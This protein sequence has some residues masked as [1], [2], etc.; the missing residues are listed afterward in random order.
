[1][2]W[3]IGCLGLMMAPAPLQAGEL[4]LEPGASATLS[5][6][7]S[8]LLRRSRLYPGQPEASEPTV[9]ISGNRTTTLR[10]QHYSGISP[11]ASA[12]FQSG[13][14]RHETTRLRIS[15][16]AMETVKI[17]GEFLQNDVDYDNKYS[18]GL[19]T[20]HYDLFLGEFPMTFKGSE[21]TLYE[22]SLQG[23]RLT[24]EVPSSSGTKPAV[25]FTL[26]SSSPRGKSQYE[27]FFGTDTQGP[28]KLK[29]SP[30]VLG[31][32]E[33]MVDKRRQVRNVDYEINYIT[34]YITFTK[35]IVESKSL[36]E[37]T[38]EA[39]KTV[40]P[41]GL[42]GG[43]AGWNITD[44]DSISLIG[45]DE[46]DGKSRD[47]YSFSGI[48]PTAHTIL[49][50][51]FRHDGEILR[52]G[53]EY[54]H[55]FY[56]PNSYGG[57]MEHGNAYRSELELEKSGL[58]LGGDI[59]RVEPKYQSMGNTALGQD[60]LGWSGYG[61]LGLGRLAALRGGHHQERS[62][63]NGSP[64]RLKTTDAKAEFTPQGWPREYYRF[65]QS[66]EVFEANYDRL[67]RRHTVDV[68]QQF[69]HLYLGSGYE[70]QEIIYRDGSQPDRSWDAGRA[71]L[72]LGGL[73]WA[74]ASFNGELRNGKES[75][76]LFGGSRKFQTAI[77]AANAGI[78]LHE[79]YYFGGSNRWQ[80][81]TGEAAQN[82]LR[83]D[84]RLRPIDQVSIQGNYSQETLQ[85]YLAGIRK[86]AR[87]DS[88]AALLETQPVKTLSFLYQPSLR[89]TVLSGTRPAVN[90]NRRDGYTAK[91]TTGSLLSAEGNCTVEDYRLRDTTDPGLR[92]QTS[93]DTDTWDTSVHLAPTTAF[94]SNISY[95]DRTSSK[96]Q[97]N[98]LSPA[99][100]DWRDTRQQAVSLGLKPQLEAKFGVDMGYR[101][102]RFRQNG[103]QGAATS[104][105]SFSISSITEKISSFSLLNDYTNLYIFNHTV[106]A[107]ASYQWVRSLISRANFTYDLKEDK[108]G[109][110]PP[111]TTISAGSG[112]TYRIKM[113]KIDCDYRL[114]QSRG[115]AGTFQQAVSSSL[116]FVPSPNVR[117]SN[118][119]EYA[120]SKNPSTAS[121]DIT[122]S[123]EVS[124]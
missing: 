119:G 103:S 52:L 88:Y 36:V 111:I 23:G 91:W 53:G 33:I 76:S 105:P 19:S 124:F 43:Q 14:T 22:R 6:P 101:F 44:Y 12:L 80:K 108:H 7:S 58:T 90:A 85:M 39:R 59:K 56:D 121:T 13:F 73:Q 98:L 42:Y 83:T 96:E 32:E 79:R 35:R 70:K 82:T 75:S 86:D 49:G 40:Y 3:M 93:Q 50:S 122:S 47:I 1:M 60:Y 20:R 48:P 15:G 95:T 109:I 123:L 89:E 5:A 114:A 63:L 62:I 18:L 100:Y 97:L 78:I 72:G 55:S 64:D 74:S 54:A 37:V 29:A 112:M 24:G 10:Y 46:R 99:L 77:I 113:L 71:S 8:P 31:S 17:E 16:Q 120:V 69:K 28:Y 87:T 92:M 2:L 9:I 115:G 68:N 107:G 30:V 81:T 11:A 51:T 4:T 66:D 38:Y 106:S 34:G 65:Y 94:S 57:G 45:L 27:R 25:E 84:A 41:R 118:R 61:G 102:E 67:E 110:I 116:D 117:W 104:L 26:V 21:F